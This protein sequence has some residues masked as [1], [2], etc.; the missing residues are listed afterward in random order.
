VRHPSIVPAIDLLQ[1]G[2][3][4]ILIEEAPDA[5]GLDRVL[6]YLRA[7][8]EALPAHIFLHI[9]TQICNALEALHG[10]PSP[11]AGADQLLHLGLRPQA[12]LVSREGR[13]R[14]GRL[15][16]VPGVGQLIG[17][18]D[19][20]GPLEYLAPE[21]THA[22]QRLSP[23]SDVFALGALLSELLTLRPLFRDQTP[24]KTIQRVRRAEIDE[25]MGEAQELLPGVEV[26][27]YRA[28]ALNPRHRYQRAFVLREDLRGLMAEF[29]FKTIHEELAAL[30]APVFVW[31]GPEGAQD[32][33]QPPEAPAEPVDEWMPLTDQRLDPDRQDAATQREDDA[34]A[35]DERTD[36]DAAAEFEVSM[37]LIRALRENTIPPDD[38]SF[39][40]DPE[41]EA[42]A[43]SPP[44]PRPAVSME[45]ADTIAPLEP[46]EAEEQEQ[47]PEPEPQAEPAPPLA[48]A[49]ASPPPAVTTWPPESSVP[50]P[51]SETPRQVTEAPPPFSAPKPPSGRSGWVNENTTLPPDDDSLDLADE[52]R[53]PPGTPPVDPLLNAARILSAAPPPRPS[54]P[55]RPMSLEDAPTVPPVEPRSRR[56]VTAIPVQRRPAAQATP[57]PL[58]QS[59][60]T[61]VPDELPPSAL[62]AS[63]TP[64]PRAVPAQAPP[65]PPQEVKA[66]PPPPP[67]PGPRWALALIPALVLVVACAGA[68][69]WWTQRAPTPEPPLAE[70]TVTP[71]EPPPVEPPPVEP[72]VEPVV[73]AIA[74]PVVEPVVEPV[75]V[76]PTTPIPPRAAKA[77]S[78]KPPPVVV[79]APLPVPAAPAVPSA[80]VTAQLI[81][82]A[83][84]GA[85]N[86]AEVSTLEGVPLASEEY[87]RSRALLVQNAEKRGD[88]DAALRYLDQLF[89]LDENRYNP[90]YLS[91]A[92]VHLVNKQRYAEALAKANEAERYWARIPADQMDRTQTDIYASQASAALGL[93]YADPDDAALLDRSIRAWERYRQHAAAR[94]DS[95]RVAKADA[96]ISRLRDMQARME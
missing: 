8:G 5:V 76:A 62:R 66:P 47:E 3:S 26:A 82:S 53:P 51:A 29:S 84:K 16:L 58:S 61:W 80:L 74:E 93:F 9:A 36:P 65:F 81:D 33:A 48:E 19:E 28:L 21:Q 52:P 91:R 77:P 2:S 75:A 86:P 55:S 34:F 37:P 85:L 78:I 40:A 67:T 70:A 38:D 31:A 20:L 44:A 11:A 13:V 71:V 39:D 96:E 24:M 83:R 30:V 72:V 35:I 41:D 32:E 43:W 64:P 69:L 79:S 88:T 17:D 50:P 7:T 25:A 45:D 14:L 15:A 89:K 46:D 59:E 27:L 10:R 54:F 22:D 1:D 6:D 60:D 56:P 68:G 92:S 4:T 73:E 95:T 49:P 18:D 94:G 90:V 63:P 42:P 23:A 12:V 87:S 57:R